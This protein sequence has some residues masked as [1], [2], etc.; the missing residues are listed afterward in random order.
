MR[1]KKILKIILILIGSVLLFLI[2]T[3]PS[4][5]KFKEFNDS[6]IQKRTKN[7]ILFSVYEATDYYPSDYSHHTTRYLGVA[8]N[9]YEMDN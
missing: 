1:L 4:M 5:N 8:L 9:F 2:V 7:Y 6:K 3:N